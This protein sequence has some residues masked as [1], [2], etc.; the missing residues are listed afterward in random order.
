MADFKRFVHKWVW[1]ALI[2]F[3]I[4]G[5]IYPVIGIAALVCMLAPSIVA[6][7][8]G[9]MWCGNFCPRGSFNDNILFRL[10]RRKNIPVFMKSNWFRNL[11]LIILMSAFAVQLTFAWGDAARIGGVFVRM[12]LIT[13]VITIILGIIFN[14]RTWCVFC[15][16]GTMAYYV[17]KIMSGLKNKYVTF[18]KDKCVSCRLCTK[19]CPV[20]IDV[21]SCKDKGSVTDHNC[22]KCNACVEKCPKKALC[23]K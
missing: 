21:L 19:A 8:R 2:A 9:R 16:M 1:I 11:F 17:T 4:V 22:L 12:I 14:Q 13:T 5:V 23:V 20:G 3:C 18:E 10:S 15:P 7:F 6:F